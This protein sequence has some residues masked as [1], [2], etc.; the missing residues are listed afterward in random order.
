MAVKNFQDVSSVE[1]L[2]PCPAYCS[3]RIYGMYGKCKMQAKFNARKKQRSK[4]VKLLRKANAHY[5]RNLAFR[6]MTDNRKFWKTIKPLFSDTIQTP[7]KIALSEGV[8]LISDDKNVAE[9]LNNYFVNITASLELSEVM[10]NL[11]ELGKLLDPTDI[12][13]NMYK[14]HPSVRSIKQRVFVRQKFSFQ[15]VT[16]E[17]KLYQTKNLDPTKPSPF[18]SIAV[19]ILA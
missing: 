3:C 15:Q 9:K 18:G 10:E 2:S 7:G 12:A 13:I 4:C 16:L 14:C 5:Y 1:T 8:E 6:N 11:I 17:M 19:K